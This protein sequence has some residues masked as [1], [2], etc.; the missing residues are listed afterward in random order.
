M[1]SP[2]SCGYCID[3]GFLCHDGDDDRVIPDD[4]DDDDDDDDDNGD[5]DRVIPE[6][7]LPRRFVEQRAWCPLV[8]TPRD[9]IN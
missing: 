9:L 3:L 7:Q 2:F 4:G 6:R 8:P 5:D 1:D